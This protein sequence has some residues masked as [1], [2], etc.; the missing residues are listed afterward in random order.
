MNDILMTNIFFAITAV[1]SIVVAVALV[2]LLV[3]II[4]LVK[5]LHYL[6]D[7]VGNQLEKVSDDVDSA[8]SAIKTEMKTGKNLKRI[9]KKILGEV[10]K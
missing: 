8:R 2:V 6:V 4:K 9:T 1:A 7:I 3:Y 5:R 10:T